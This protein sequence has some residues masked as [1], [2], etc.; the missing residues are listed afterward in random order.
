MTTPTRQSNTWAGSRRL[1]EPLGRIVGL[2]FAAVIVLYA[3]VTAV[4]PLASG[5][6]LT[7]TTSADAYVRSDQATTNFGNATQLASNAASSNVMV[8]YLSFEVTGLTGPPSSAIL[9]YYSQSSGVT[10]TAVH[11]VSVA[12]SETSI[13]YSN[14]PGYGATIASTAALSAG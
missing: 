5:A 7:I 6:T 10:K 12:W 13:N 9:S 14:K 3:A 11:V 8:S 2:T 1:P 4:S